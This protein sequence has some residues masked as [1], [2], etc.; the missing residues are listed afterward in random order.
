[1]LESLTDPKLRPQ[2]NANRRDWLANMPKV[3]GG[4]GRELTPAENRFPV[5]HTCTLECEC[6]GKQQTNT[7]INKITWGARGVPW[8]LRARKEMDFLCFGFW[9]LKQE[10]PGWFRLAS[11]QLTYKPESPHP[12]PVKLLIQPL[13]PLF[14]AADVAAF[15]TAMYITWEL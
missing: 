8:A 4:R 13:L 6:T 3:P 12:V 14:N 10:P 1:M 11:N 9:V 7:Q 2:E 15:L 5:L